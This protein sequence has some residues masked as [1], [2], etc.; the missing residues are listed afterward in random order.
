MLKQLFKIT[1]LDAVIRAKLLYGLDSAQLTPSQQR[2][3]EVFQLKGLR[4]I[5]KMKTTYVER[6]NSNAE[7]FRRANEH[8]RNETPQGKEPKQIRQLLACY[9]N[10]RMKR[11][12]RIHAMPRDH[13]VRHITFDTNQPNP[14]LI[15]PWIPPN[16]RVGRPR[17]KWVTE[18]LNDMWTNLASIHPHVTQSF[19]R[20]GNEHQH[21]IIRKEMNSVEPRF[22]FK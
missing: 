7:V 12:A 9:K 14:N 21:E 22:F 2:R 18:T 20:T 4:N 8:I 5:L 15:L 1:T 13:P 19:D 11:L 16:R 17:Y 3:I 6:N 10:S